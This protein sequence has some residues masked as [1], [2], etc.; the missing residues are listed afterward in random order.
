MK[1][2]FDIPEKCGDCSF[3]RMFND[4]HV[5]TFPKPTQEE[6]MVD[7]TAY[8]VPTDLRPIWCPMCKTN[9]LYNNLPEDKQKALIVIANF[10][11]ILYS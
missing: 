9:D 6:S 2:L 4:K 10:I 8:K 5:C 3:I 7:I 11:R 1:D